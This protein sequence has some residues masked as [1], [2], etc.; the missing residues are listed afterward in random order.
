MTLKREL[1]VAVVTARE[2]IGDNGTR[3]ASGTAGSL[4]SPVWKISLF[5]EVQREARFKID[6][7]PLSKEWL[8]PRVS[9]A[10]VIGAASY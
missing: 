1:A 4:E 2:V 6:T 9:E 3:L 10:S 8:T 7:E 5:F